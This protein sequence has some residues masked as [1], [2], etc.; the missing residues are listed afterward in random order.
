M[1]YSEPTDLAVLA[2]P[3]GESFADEVIKHL[4]HIYSRR[5]RQKS[6]VLAKR[7]EVDRT[8]LIV[9]NYTIVIDRLSVF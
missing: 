9:I 5:F 1:T 8:S 4:N 3:G 6:D 2:C 7:Y